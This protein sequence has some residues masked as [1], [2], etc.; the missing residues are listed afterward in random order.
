MHKIVQR[1]TLSDALRRFR[2]LAPG[3][4][5]S[6]VIFDAAAATPFAP[7]TANSLRIVANRCMEGGGQTLTLRL[8]EYLA[9]GPGGGWSVY[10][11]DRDLSRYNPFE[12]LVTD[13]GLRTVVEFYAL[14]AEGMAEALVRGREE[15]HPEEE[16]GR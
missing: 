12:I 4:S 3:E 6:V 5:A 9:S 16:A 7:C 13:D 15:D 11:A 8:E 14:E 2:A 1:K 10:N